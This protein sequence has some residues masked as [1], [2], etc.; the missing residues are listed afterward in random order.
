[1]LVLLTLT[2]GCALEK[3]GLFDQILQVISFTGKTAGD[4]GGAQGDGQGNGVEGNVLVPWGDRAFLMKSS[5]FIYVD[6]LWITG[7]TPH[8]TSLPS[9][10]YPNLAS[11]VNKRSSVLI[12]YHD[13]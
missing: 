10:P 11:V 1:M 2:Q 4:E 9:E 12:L 8:L 7:S 3:D 13:R 5:I 6:D